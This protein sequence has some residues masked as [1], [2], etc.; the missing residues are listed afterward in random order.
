MRSSRLS[1]QDDVGHQNGI[2]YLV[3]E[4]LEG[5][6]LASRLMKSPLPTEHVLKYGFEICEGLE[7][8]HKK[9]RYSSI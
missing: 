5:E 2:D 9:W 6:T 3:M 8:A 7:K 1:A 4:Y